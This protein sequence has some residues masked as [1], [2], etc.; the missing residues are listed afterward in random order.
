MPYC[1]HFVGCHSW[2]IGSWRPAHPLP[3][4]M[5]CI[6]I[7]VTPDPLSSWF[8][9]THLPEAFSLIAQWRNKLH[10]SLQATSV[11]EMRICPHL[12]GQHNGAT[13]HRYVHAPLRLQHKGSH[14]YTQQ[15]DLHEASSWT[16]CC[17]SKGSPCWSVCWPG[18]APWRRGNPVFLAVYP[19]P[20]VRCLL[21]SE[22]SSSADLPAVVS[23]HIIVTKS[24]QIQRQS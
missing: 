13:V 12:E 5:P 9:F 15:S 2:L 16:T 24:C 6:C 22:L 17:G 8:D 20:A 11:I 4:H 21:D 7:C 14:A 3:A 23:C 18:R 19:G 10:Q 1:L